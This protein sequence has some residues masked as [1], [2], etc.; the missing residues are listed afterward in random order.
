MPFIKYPDLE[1]LRRVEYKEL[2]IGREM[3]VT[4]KRDGQ[5]VSNYMDNGVPYISSHH[6]ACAPED[7]EKRIKASQDYVGAIELLKDYPNVNAFGELLSGRGPTKVEID[8]KTI[9]EWHLFDIL[10]GST[11]RWFDYDKLTSLSSAYKIRLVQCL[12]RFTPNS[13]DEIEAMLSEMMTWC[14][15]NHYEGV[16]CKTY[17]DPKTVMFKQRVVIEVSKVPKKDKPTGLVLPVMDMERITR[18][19]QHA[20]DEVTAAHGESGWLDTKIAMPAIA[21]H[22]HLEAAEHGVA[23]PRDMFR[24]YN[25]TLKPGTTLNAKMT[26]ERAD[27]LSQITSK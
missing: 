23:I 22:F 6:Q 5:N 21:K 7:I 3:V 25:D 17:G 15:E 20:Y 26:G 10:D 16:V 27:R 8:V 11:Y 12:R 13:I 4:V 14:N 1:S 18:S 24:L 19:L 9:P 2:L